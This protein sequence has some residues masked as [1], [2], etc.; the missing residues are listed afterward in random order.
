M[1]HF[2]IPTWIKSSIFGF[3][4]IISLKVKVT[5]AVA[6]KQI[7]H[8]IF[9][10]PEKHGITSVASVSFFP[11]RKFSRASRVLGPV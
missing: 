5:K 11:R 1:A 3:Q 9:H 4:Y 7:K 6:L 2:P 8:K 10:F